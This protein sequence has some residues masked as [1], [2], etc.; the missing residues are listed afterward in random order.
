MANNPKKIVSLSEAQLATLAGGGSI[1]SG[2]DTYTAD[3]D[4]LYL[5]PDVIDNAP[6]QN[7]TNPVTSG[8]VYTALAGKQDALPTTSTAGQLLQS[9]STSGTLQFGN[10]LPYLTTEPSSANTDGLIIVVLSSEPVTRYS[11]YLYIITS[12]NS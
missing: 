7:S 4:T 8:G 2:S 5:T 9:T 10:S 11:G 6:T 12:S 1:T 3:E